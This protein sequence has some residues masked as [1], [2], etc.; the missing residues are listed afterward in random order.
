MVPPAEQSPPNDCKKLG[1]HPQRLV[2]VIQFKVYQ[3]LKAWM[4]TCDLDETPGECS[5][6][7]RLTEIIFEN[8]N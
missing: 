4:K 5:Y 2:Q 7:G 6:F 3:V 8:P 1:G